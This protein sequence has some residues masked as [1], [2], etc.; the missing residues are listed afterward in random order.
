MSI[1][2]GSAK[3]PKLTLMHGCRFF[4]VG[5]TQDYLLCLGKEPS[6]DNGG[7]ERLTREAIKG[8]ATL[9]TFDRTHVKVLWGD[10]DGIV[11]N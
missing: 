10:Q 9:D 1:G 2:H 5:F 6:M 4:S 8:L 11:S 7:L 3:F